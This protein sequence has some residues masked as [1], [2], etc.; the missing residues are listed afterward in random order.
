MGELGNSVGAGDRAKI[1]QYLD[2]VRDVE[3]RIQVAEAQS[4]REIVTI[5]QPAG[6]PESYEEH[7]KNQLGVNG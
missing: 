6:T 7:A 5:D 3:R 2:S 1:D 4:D